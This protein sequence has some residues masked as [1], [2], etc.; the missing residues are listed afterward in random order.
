V[1]G[2]GRRITGPDRH[3]SFRGTAKALAAFTA[4]QVSRPRFLR[5]FAMQAGPSEVKS[6]RLQR[7]SNLAL[8]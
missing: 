8:M 6:L 3:A 2:Y 7:T 1:S 4:R 5:I